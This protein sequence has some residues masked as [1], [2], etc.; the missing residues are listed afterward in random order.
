MTEMRKAWPPP[1]P[2]DYSIEREAVWLFPWVATT[3]VGPGY[4]VLCSSGQTRWGTERRHRRR[5]QAL[6]RKS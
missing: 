5:L 4:R 6:E 3:L 1:K 2:P